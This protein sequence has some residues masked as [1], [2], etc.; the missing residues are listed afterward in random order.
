MTAVI[1]IAALVL[2]VALGVPIA[3]SIVLS[4]MAG[5]LLGGS[6]NLMMI[7]SQMFGG[8]NSFTL[9]AI[10]MFALMGEIM[11]HTSLGNKFINIASELVGWLKGGLA[12][13]TV[14]VCMMFGTISGSAVAAAAALT[15]VLVPEME[16]RGYPK[17]LSVSVMSSASTLA[18]I[19]PPSSI[20]IIYGVAAGVS[21][22]K[23]YLAAIVPGV[24][25]GSLLMVVAYVFARKM[26]LPVENKFSIKRLGKALLSGWAALLIP[27][28]IFVGIFGGFCTP[29]EAAAISVV[30]ALLS[31][32]KELKLKDLPKMLVRTAT[33]TAIVTFMVAGSAALVAVMTISKVPQTITA[34]ITSITTNKY[35]I[36][37][38]LN[39]LLFVLGMILHGNAII[40]L[41]IPLA[42]P[43]MTALG[44]D[45]I[46]FGILMCLNV[47][48]GQQ[49]PLSHLFCL[50]PA[51]L[52]VSRFRRCGST[53]NGSCCLQLFLCSLSATSLGSHYASFD[54]NILYLFK[55]TL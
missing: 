33:S 32:I 8:V 49:T 41:V 5:I 15:G 39:A 27:L 4:G 12:M 1:I 45:P 50:P 3:F 7:C 40:M 36:L 44:V 21:I 48:I 22:S 38:M 35:L 24:L 9:M 26:N 25:A 47:G 18:I 10:P 37:L 53:S 16:K 2:F 31:G 46:H 52:P 34:F 13:A 17:E 20:L 19:I 11:G 29:T 51:P 54:N 23:L 55:P 6:G 43:I 42:L 28:V 30:V 14:V